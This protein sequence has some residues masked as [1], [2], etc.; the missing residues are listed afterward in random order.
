MYTN[1]HD[2]ISTI[3]FQ[4]SLNFI[5]TINFNASRVPF[6][7]YSSVIYIYAHLTGLD[8][9]RKWSI[10]PLINSQWLA[11]QWFAYVS[12]RLAGLYTVWPIRARAPFILLSPFLSLFA[13]ATINY[14]NR[15]ERK[16]GKRSVPT[17]THSPCTSLPAWP[18]SDNNHFIHCLCRAMADLNYFPLTI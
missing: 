3:Y 11:T 4:T 6:N 8:K 14:P 2:F 10:N 16:H 18:H 13:V 9:T 7:Y 5:V 1:W 12:F 17:S 15:G